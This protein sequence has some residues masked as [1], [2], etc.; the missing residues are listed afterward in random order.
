MI[1]LQMNIKWQEFLQFYT[2]LNVERKDYD[3]KFLQDHRIGEEAANSEDSSE[4]RQRDEEEKASD[5]DFIINKLNE[6]K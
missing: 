1:G 2:G 6:F 3:R 4:A 5:Q